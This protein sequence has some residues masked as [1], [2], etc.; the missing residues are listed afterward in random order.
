MLAAH[1]G[2]CVLH[3]N[4]G[5][6]D[7]VYLVVKC[8]MQLIVHLGVNDHHHIMAMTR[9]LCAHAWLKSKNYKYVVASTLVVVSKNAWKPRGARQHGPDTVITKLCK[10]LN[11]SA[12]CQ[13]R[14]LPVQLMIECR[15][16]ST[17]S[18]KKFLKHWLNYP[19]MHAM[20]INLIEFL[21]RSR[22]THWA[23]FNFLSAISWLMRELI[24]FPQ[25]SN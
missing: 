1:A 4:N 16:L 15:N 17:N 21:I 6:L 9:P 22:Q 7:H 25:C 19:L 10:V 8:N 13:W 5:C 12:V 14:P 2:R 11:L 3:S 18:L 23:T 20:C 24:R